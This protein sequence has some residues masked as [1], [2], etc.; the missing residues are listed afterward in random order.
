MSRVPSRSCAGTAKVAYKF[1]D[2]SGCAGSGLVTLTYRAHPVG[3]PGTLAACQGTTLTFDV[4]ANDTVGTGATIDCNSLAVPNPPPASQ[5]TLSLNQPCGAGT[6]PCAGKCM[7]FVPNASFTGTVTFAYNFADNTGCTGNGQVTLTY[8]A[9]PVGL[10][11]T[12]TACQ[13]TTLT[14]DVLA[15]AP[16][17]TG[18]S[19]YSTLFRSPNPP[20]ASQGTLSLNQP[21]GAGTHPCAG[22]CMTFVPNASFVGTV[23]FTYNFADNSGCA[24]SGQV[25]LTYRANPVGVP[26]TLSA[27]Q[28]TTLTFDVLEIGRAHV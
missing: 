15:S 23:T 26:D 7:T 18:A 8:R 10:P 24:A 25:S 27:C 4:L 2:N 19:L 6:H 9:S 3:V 12:L 11:D 20:P 21:C 28:G 17:G 22:K 13:G 5:G 14:F 1:A 16:V